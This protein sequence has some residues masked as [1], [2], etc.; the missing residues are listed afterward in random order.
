[1]INLRNT[2]LLMVIFAMILI[3]GS[4]QIGLDPVPK[5]GEIAPDFTVA[6]ND[7][8]FSLHDLHGKYVLV[9]FWSS[10]D[11]NSRIK[12]NEYNKLTLPENCNIRRLSV[13]F[14]RSREL[15]NEIV[16][17]DHLD[18]SEQYFAGDGDAEQLAHD[19]A[20]GRA[21]NSYLINPDG[22]IIA[23]NPDNKY[24]TGYF[25]MRPGLSYR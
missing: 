4:K 23:V 24:L 11:A 18:P 10:A 14:D 25:K 3:F 19:Y 6:R 16:T 12:S 2:L 5:S 13:N 17:R 20:V 9:D 1:M 21:Y 22:E 8:A 15:F 7:T